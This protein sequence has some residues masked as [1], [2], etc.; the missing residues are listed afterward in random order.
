MTRLKLPHRLNRILLRRLHPDDLDAFLAYRADP[1]VARFQGWSPMSS[2]QALAFLQHESDLDALRPGQW[3]QLGVTRGD[4]PDLIG[5]A[6]IHLSDDG[7][8]AEIG[9]SLSRPAQGQGLGTELA[10]GLIELVFSSTSVN[11]VLAHADLRNE[12]CMRAL[13]RAGMTR[14][15][16][17]KTIWKDELCEE[18]CFVQRRNA[19]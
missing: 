15:A 11:E 3:S 14:F 8:T 17:R 19:G 9:M 2:E 10:G 4:E 6:G 16:T 13:Q 1:Q 5:D 18:A 7:M 12:P